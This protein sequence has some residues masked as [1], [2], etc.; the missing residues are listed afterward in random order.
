MTDSVKGSMHEFPY[1]Q[2]FKIKG[3]SY[4]ELEHPEELSEQEA[5][6]EERKANAEKVKTK[7]EA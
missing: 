1:A 6:L 4:E 3:V 5:I 2:N 7:V